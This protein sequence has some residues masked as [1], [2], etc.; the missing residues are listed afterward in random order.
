MK[1]TAGNSEAT[2]HRGF[3]PEEAISGSIIATL[4]A[5]D[6][7]LILLRRAQVDW[8]NYF[9]NLSIGVAALVVG[10]YYR[11]GDRSE[12]LALAAIWSALFIFFTN[13]CSTF[14][15]L[16]LPTGPSTLDPILASIDARLGYSWLSTLKFMGGYPLTAQLLKPLYLSTIIQLF[17]LVV[18]LALTGRKKQLMRLQLAAIVG[19]LMSIAIWYVAPSFGPSTMEEVPHQLARRIGLLIAAEQAEQLRLV[20]V[21]GPILLSP[22][23]TLGLVAFPSVHALMAC[24]VVWF[25]TSIRRL[26][27]PVAVINTAMVP[28]ILIHGGHHLIDVIGGIAMFFVA[29]LLADWLIGKSKPS[30]DFHLQSPDR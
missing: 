15:T 6:L 29:L 30:V 24:L 7:L 17:A 27:F 28:A 9:I 4:F 2:S 3:E 5:I 12:P 8:Q 1:F 11:R 25:S 14:N 13:A 18:V 19:V 22:K 26:F 16:L 20:A 23:D 21:H 10:L